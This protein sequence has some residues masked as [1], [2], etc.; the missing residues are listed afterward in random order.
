MV[1]VQKRYLVVKGVLKA[2]WKALAATKQVVA[3][4]V[5][6][7]TFSNNYLEGTNAPDT[8]AVRSA[9]AAIV[10]E[11]I[12]KR[13]VPYPETIEVL[14]A[15]GPGGKLESGCK[16]AESCQWTRAL[17]TWETVPKFKDPKDEA[18]RVYNI[19][20]AHEMLAYSA[21]NSRDFESSL[22]YL[23]KAA[24]NYGS[25]VDLNAGEKYFRD[26]QTR[27]KTSLGYYTALKE[28]SSNGAPPSGGTPASGGTAAA[29]AAAA[30]APGASSLTNDG[31]IDFVRN[32]FS[33]SF[34][35]DQIRT[36]RTPQFN[37]TPAE[38]VKLKQ[39]GV[40]ERIITEMLQRK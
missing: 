24:E 32:G 29:A 28:Q 19:G 38:L 10:I 20:L 18:Y 5:A 1:N 31:I 36:S 23:G 14:V 30:A 2:T 27:I 17:E 40:S 8:G 33:E 3:S 4:D 13:L 15:K 35:L 6:A 12:A 7:A 26:P 25:A 34:V 21:G 37:V 16:F 9:M 11:A 39:A 22:T